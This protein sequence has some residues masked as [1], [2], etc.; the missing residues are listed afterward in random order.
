MSL[1]CIKVIV[2]NLAKS[3][4]FPQ[5]L[6]SF[7][8]I[9]V[10]ISREETKVVTSSLEVSLSLLLWIRPFALESPDEQASQKPKHHFTF[11]VQC[12][13]G[14]GSV[15]RHSRMWCPH[16]IGR[17]SWV[18]GEQETLY[19][20]H[21]PHEV[22]EEALPKRRPL[23]GESVPWNGLRWLL[24]LLLF[25]WFFLVF[26]CFFEIFFVF[27]VVHRLVLTV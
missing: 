7:S 3:V 4:L 21:S 22:G 27:F 10:E 9:V 5:E 8:H 13:R 15:V 25:S 6:Q 26:L 19:T 2:V 24:L 18:W 23:S 14:D 11:D 17:D 20:I 12:L 1:A 16:D